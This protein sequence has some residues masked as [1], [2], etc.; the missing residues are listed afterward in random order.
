VE[1]VEVTPT[2]SSAAAR[3]ELE[4]DGAIVRLCD[5]FD[6]DDLRTVI[7]VLRERR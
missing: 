7:A 5:G 1:F 3:I 2:A 6:V 4:V